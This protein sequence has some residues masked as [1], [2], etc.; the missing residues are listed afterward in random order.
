MF[1][2]HNNTLSGIQKLMADNKGG[3][4][5]FSGDKGLGKCTAAKLL[6]ARLLNAGETNLMAH[7]DF[8]IMSSQDDVIK[9]D[10]LD[11][12]KRFVSFVPANAGIKVSIIDD[13]DSMTETA[14]NSLL[15]LLED[16][17]QSNLIILIAHHP[18]LETIR[19]R[20]M[21][22]DFLP[23]N[24]KEMNQAFDGKGMDPQLIRFSCGHPGMV[25]RLTDSPI[26]EELKKIV[27][28]VSSMKQTRELLEIF[29]ILKEKDKNSFFDTH[30]SEEV[31]VLLDVLSDLFFKAV[32]G[33]DYLSNLYGKQDLFCILQKIS[34]AK[35]QIRRKG[36]FGKNDFFDLICSMVVM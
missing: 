23:L 35:N 16:G 28:S 13:A 27:N 10:D 12:L 2:L 17:T 8:F 30:T 19:S 26:G 25:Y 20:S 22:V 31:V 1:V 24:E 21:Q 14:Q 9:V 29:S 33:Q 15:K 3:F 36:Q 6:A 4:Y 32:N 5:L 34:I 7:P 18:V 11:E